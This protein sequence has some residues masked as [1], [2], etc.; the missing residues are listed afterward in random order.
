MSAYLL[1]A[2]AIAVLLLSHVLRAIRLAPM[3]PP[4]YQV[5]RFDLLLGLAISYA[6]GTVVPFR[7]GEIVRTLYVG[8]RCNVRYSY[9][10]ATILVERLFDAICAGLI[11]VALMAGAFL[12]YK[13]LGPT[14]II[15]FTIGFGGLFLAFAIQRSSSLRHGIWHVASLFRTGICYSI[16]DF[17]WA[18]SE[19]VTG[20]V[21]G[22]TRFLL[23]TPPMWFLYLVSYALFGRAVHFQLSDVIYALLG[24]PLRPLAKQSHAAFQQP[25]FALLVF[26]LTPVLLILLYGFMRE[27]TTIFRVFNSLLSARYFSA[28]ARVGPI[29]ARF[30]QA[31]EYQSFLLSRFTNRSDLLADFG[32]SAILDGT[33]Q[34]LFPGGSDAI[35]ALVEVDDRLLIRKFALGEAGKKLQGQ[36]DW[37]REHQSDLPLVRVVGERSGSGFYC[38]DMPY[39]PS[40]SDFYDVIH[41]AT[42]AE[43]QQILGQVIEHMVQFHDRTATGSATRETVARYLAQ[44][45]TRN[46]QQVIEHTKD[47]LV[48]GSSRYI[49]NGREYDMADW[50]YLLDPAWLDKQVHDLRTCSVHGDL[51]IE[52]IIVNNTED[53]M[54]IID[55]NPE[56]IFNSPLIDWAKLMQS[57]HLGYEALNKGPSCKWVNG[58]FSLIL[59]RSHAYNE[60][61]HFSRRNLEDRF[62]QEILREITFHEL[63]NYLRLTPYKL[64]NAPQKGLTFFA[65]T[66][67]LLRQYLE[68]SS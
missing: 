29:S 13:Q 42:Q 48:E 66:S 50:Q 43:S 24:S 46:A 1:F 28:I 54:Y 15:L 27:R 52:N 9:V 67:I 10:A 39:F 16:L 59:T 45:A 6:I 23:L 60:L 47:W 26:T 25:E 20:G 17:F 35:T 41:T 53:G 14:A 56:N 68:E 33:V 51:T 4:Q 21:T 30:K 19:I 44:K 31:S 2:I 38:Y 55:P 49:L 12:P 61:F 22:R 5:R 8:R 32:M 3:Y 65:C 37:L 63:I 11:L 18:F 40:A 36:A 58:S 62:G 34:R 7:V 64:R 57:L